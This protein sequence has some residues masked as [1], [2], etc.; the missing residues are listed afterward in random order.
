MTTT[1]LKT[2]KRSRPWKP[3]ADPVPRDLQY[4]LPA[5]M[6][7]AAPGL[8]W[9][10]HFGEPP[11]TLTADAWGPDVASEV[12]AVVLISSIHAHADRQGKANLPRA[13]RLFARKPIQ[14]A[15]HRGDCIT[16]RAASSRIGELL[17]FPIAEVTGPRLP[18]EGA[19]Q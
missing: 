11:V 7:W 16:V 19:A 6:R 2:P 12:R 8:R 3:H 17:A 14:V 9:D 4:K 15:L 13:S 1:P 18:G 10:F 5:G